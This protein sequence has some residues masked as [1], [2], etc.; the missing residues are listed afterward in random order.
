ME[1]KD[2]ILEK[3]KF[4][5][6]LKKKSKQMNA[7]GTCQQIPFKKTMKMKS[8]INAGSC[9]QLKLSLGPD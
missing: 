8:H 4:T 1:K 9:N 3:D 6:N 5:D 7:E 2:Y